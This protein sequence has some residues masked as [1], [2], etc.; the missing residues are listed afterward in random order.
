M[1][2]RPAARR[3]DE[4]QLAPMPGTQ[5]RAPTFSS[6]LDARAE[7]ANNRERSARPTTQ[8]RSIHAIG[9]GLEAVREKPA[10]PEPGVAATL[11]LAYDEEQAPSAPRLPADCDRDTIAREL[12]LMPG[13]DASELERIRR[14]FA[15][16]SHP[17]RALP[18]QRELATRRM[19]V[20]NM[21]IDEAL[22]QR[23]GKPQR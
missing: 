9:R 3:Q 22:A 15:L 17:D 8:A 12:G 5:Q 18:Q 1:I 2:P 23:R 19:S 20:A 14:D 11:A 10:R 13:L 7:A 4:P 16:A 6:L 21:L